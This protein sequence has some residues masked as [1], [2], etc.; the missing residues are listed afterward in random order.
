MTRRA[1][2][3]GLI[4]GLA[5]TACSVIGFGQPLC[6]FE[7]PESTIG[8]ANLSFSYRHFDDGCTPGIDASNGWLTG[9]LE[10]LHD[11][12]NFGY[13]MWVNTQIELET[14]VA[15]SWLGSGSMSYRYY[16]AEELP[17]FLYA[18]VRVDAAT[19]FVQPG[20][21]VRSGIGIGRFRD[22]TPLAQ[23]YRI[24]DE[25]L[26]SGSIKHLPSRQD[27]LRIAERI[28][29]EDSF[30]TFDEY[31]SSVAELVR[32]VVG[33]TLASSSVLEIRDR[34]ENGAVERYCG[35]I[36]Q[37]GVGF[38]LVDPYRGTEDIL[39]VVSGDVGRALRPDA[40]LR[41][42]LSVSGASEDFLGE[43]NSSLELIY[44]ALLPNERG[45]RADYTVQRAASGQSDEAVL[46]QSATV[47]YTLGVGTADLAF[48]LALS[49]ESGDPK[50][51]VDLSVSLALDLL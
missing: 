18:G 30:D 39:Y 21:E 11:S 24:V 3:N 44:D 29:G 8:T 25:L 32:S 37:Y 19:Y 26:R 17:L 13:T 34:L 38:E 2:V 43:N 20:C 41:C 27:I 14:W 33:G 50:W 42:R 35:A 49:R 10:R 47:E 23:A 28:A 40:Q 51:S 16:F 6:Q 45:V 7:M 46:F 5:V 12:P 36:V 9:R 15:T 31:V 4:L 48:D 22:V 1:C